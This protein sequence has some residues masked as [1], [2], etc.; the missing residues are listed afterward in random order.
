METSEIFLRAKR[1]PLDVDFDGLGVERHR[2]GDTVGGGFKE[3]SLHACMYAWLVGWLMDYVLVLA[4]GCS[5][6][7]SCHIM[8]C[9]VQLYLLRYHS[10]EQVHRADQEEVNSKEKKS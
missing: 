9:H 4:V 5:V 2:C 6:I 8:S 3:M 1:F 10:Y 7:M